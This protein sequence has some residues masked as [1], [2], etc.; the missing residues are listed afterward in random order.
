MCA[1]VL[2]ARIVAAFP[3]EPPF[4]SLRDQ[5]G[6]LLIRD[7]EPY[8]NDISHVE[9]ARLGSRMTWLEPAHSI[10]SVLSEPGKFN[11]F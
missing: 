10:G 11:L 7:V 5:R 9:A 6:A 2:I 3:E 8:S 1:I 4:F